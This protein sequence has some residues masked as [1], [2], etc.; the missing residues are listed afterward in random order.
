VVALRIKPDFFENGGEVD[1]GIHGEW[2]NKYRISLRK[3]VDAYE[4]YKH[5]FHSKQ[6]EIVC[7]GSLRDCI[8]YCNGR[9]NY[10]DEVVEA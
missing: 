5:Y 10:Q 9:F 1:Y 7:C 6:D 2:G 3:A 8:A 4:V